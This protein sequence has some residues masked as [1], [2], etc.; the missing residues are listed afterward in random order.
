L[1]L[2]QTF[3]YRAPN[4]RSVGMRATEVASPGVVVGIELSQS[5]GSEALVD[6]AQ[7]GQQDRVISANASGT[8]T[9]SENG[10]EL[11]GNAGECVLDRQRVDGEIAA[12]GNSPLLERIEIQHRIPRPNDRR[13]FPD[14]PWAEARTGSISSS[15]IVWNADQRD[16]EILRI[17]HMR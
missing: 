1:P 15:T 4:R 14:M 9:R 3:F 6:G 12:V 5:D 17:A 7:D 10:I 13:L 2:N 11:F 8:R 16:V